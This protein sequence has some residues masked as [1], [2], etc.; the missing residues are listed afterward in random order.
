MIAILQLQTE[1]KS[2]YRPQTAVT[3]LQGPPYV[4]GQAIMPGTRYP[5]MI[6]NI[7]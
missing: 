3:L 2:T 7:S 4:L 1:H 5:L 6:L